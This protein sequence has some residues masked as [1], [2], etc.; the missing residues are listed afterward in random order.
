MA[1][2][3]ICTPHGGKVLPEYYRHV[4]T[5]QNNSLGHTFFHMEVD[6]MIIGKAR[7]ILVSETLARTEAEV[8]W[9][10]DNDIMIPP[11]AGVLI[12]Q[13]LK[14]GIVSGLYFNRHTPYTPQAY[15]LST[16]PGEKGL[17][18]PIMKYPALGIM[19]VDA[20]GAGC[21]AI[22]RKVVEEMGTA[23]A[24]RLK[25]AEELLEHKLRNDG[26]ARKEYE[27]LMTYART[28]SP[29][30]EFLDQR[31]EDF[32]FC[33]R[34]REQGHPIFLNVEVKC[35]HVGTLGFSE[36]HFRYL[37]DNDLYVRMGTDGKPV[38]EK[39]MQDGEQDPS[40]GVSED[41]QVP[42]TDAPST[43]REALEWSNL[44]D[45]EPGGF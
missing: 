13:A 35:I 15:M 38:E 34:A 23:H 44:A 3:A 45:G 24:V 14:Y 7:N 33:E 11:H 29:W 28:L 39:E 10:I 43:G 31:G 8:L 22:N 41:E 12:D 16:E 17:Y 4:L 40:S 9:F 42:D 30:F 18:E 21:L 37:I 20:V 5:M 2:V 26:K 1:K 6:L 32:Y 27:W 25:H 19:M 36:G